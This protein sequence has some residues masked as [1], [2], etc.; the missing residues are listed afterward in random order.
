MA[1]K[2]GSSTLT[3][4]RARCDR[5]KAWSSMRILPQFTVPDLV[6]TA[7]I[8]ESNAGKYVQGLAVFG[9]LRIIQPKAEGR[10]GGHAVYKLIRNTGPLAP[11]LRTDGWVYDP[12]TGDVRQPA[13]GAQ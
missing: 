12:N 1:R 2:K 6:A 9:Y 8:G 13:G 11:R 10:K 4:R 5:D 3:A 7:E